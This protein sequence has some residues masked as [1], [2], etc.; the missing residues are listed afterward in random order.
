VKLFGWEFIRSEEDIKQDE[1]LKSITPSQNDGS[2]IVD[3]ST[4]SEYAGWGGAMG[5]SMSF[6][7]DP[8]VV[9]EQA[10]ISKYREM[11][12]VPEVELAVDDILNAMASTEENKVVTIDLDEV[13]YSN[14]LKKKIADEFDY[15]L[16]LLDFNANAYEI[17][18][19]WY[20]DGR[21]YYQ[22]I[23]D[24]N[25]YKT[26][27]ISKLSYIDPRLIKKVKVVKKDKDQHTGADVYSDKDEYYIF[28]ESGFGTNQQVGTV[29]T[30]NQNNQGV[31]LAKE[32]VAY[33]HSGVLNPTN[34]VVLSHL[35]KIIRP[36]NQLKS[37][38]DAA[39]IYRLSRA[40]E[41]RVFYIDVGNLPPAKAEQV[42]QRQMQQYKSKMVYDTATGTVRSDPK[43]MTMIEDYW[44]PRRGDGKATEITT[45]PGGQNLGE[46]TEVNYFLQKLYKALNVPISRLDQQ[47]GF[48]FG[49]V[50]EINRDEVKFMKFVGRLRKRFS[51]LFLELLK[52]QLALKNILNPDEFDRIKHQISF[53]FA[54]DNIFQESMNIEIL[55]AR[56]TLLSTVTGYEASHISHEWV[57][58]NVLQ[59]SDEEIEEIKKQRK[60]EEKDGT[61]DNPIETRAQEIAA[62]QQ[63]APMQVQ[64]TPVQGGA[65]SSSGG[66]SSSPKKQTV[67]TQTQK[68]AD[69]QTRKTTTVK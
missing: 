38:E 53:E 36:L 22:V 34:T 66:N 63:P 13:E 49:R 60:T 9:S 29:D 61:F 17:L 15:V 55:T 26:E 40:P 7:I 31:R 41:R 21:L 10:L 59:F 28:S 54:S 64:L 2:I 57:M 14:S 68:L 56:F 27:G 65:Q 67:Q 19:R 58:R 32:A 37:L 39:I 5:Y 23:I 45:L 24:Q 30:I 3:Q 11:S 25:L 44:L 18:R 6:D 69:G 48:N 46:M 52:R 8:E 35:H 62:A 1:S 33:S 20:V 47:A 50:T 16:S 42:L 12:L 51:T 43:H 4:V